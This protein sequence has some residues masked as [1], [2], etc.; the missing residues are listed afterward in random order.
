MRVLATV[1]EPSHV[2]RV[3][4]HL[5]LRADPLELA[6]ARD[7]TWLQTDLGFVA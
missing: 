2:R 6:P 1:V 4:E 3:L 7:P 5:G